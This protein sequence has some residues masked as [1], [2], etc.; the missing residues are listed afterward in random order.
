MGA[1]LSLAPSPVAPLAV[2][3][4]PCPG[5]RHPVAFV[6]WHL[7]LCRGCGRQ[8]ASQACLLPLLWCAAPRPVRSPS[9]LRS[10]L[11]SPWCLPPPGGLSPPALL[12]G[13]AAQVEAG[14]EPGSLCLRLAPV[15]AGAL[16]S[17]RVVPVSGPAMGLSLASP[18]GF[19]LGLPALRWFG[20]RGPGH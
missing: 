19:G 3:C 4:A 11:P 15:E 10:A 5:L 9:V 7:P 20:V 16:S 1:R 13:C 2:C 17:L 14:R 6:V 18:S 8:G 12:G